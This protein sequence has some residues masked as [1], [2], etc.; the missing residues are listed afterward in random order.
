MDREIVFRGKR[1]DDVE[2]VAGGYA[3][4]EGKPYIVVIYR[5]PDEGKSG[6]GLSR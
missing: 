4:F 3:E 5:V 1:V 2:W 6:L